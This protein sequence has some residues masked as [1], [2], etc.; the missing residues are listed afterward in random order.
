MSGCSSGAGGN[1]PLGLSRYFAKLLC[2]PANDWK[3]PYAILV[4]N[5]QE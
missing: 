4:A 2:V 5:K 3:S 1:K